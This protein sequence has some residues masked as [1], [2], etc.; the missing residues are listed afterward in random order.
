MIVNELEDMEIK[1]SIKEKLGKS[2]TA[3]VKK[4]K[5]PVS[6]YFLRQLDTDPQG[7][8]IKLYLLTVATGEPNANLEDLM[9]LWN[10]SINNFETCR[11]ELIEEGL[12]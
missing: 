7:L 6:Y 4:L 9:V 12:L 11:Q 10:V 3:Y 8:F 1:T 5:K 2:I